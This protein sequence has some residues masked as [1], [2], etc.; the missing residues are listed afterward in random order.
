MEE[1]MPPQMPEPI[2]QQSNFNTVNPMPQQEISTGVGTLPPINPPA[3]KRMKW[4][5]WLI[6][7][8]AGAAL[9]GVGGLLLHKHFSNKPFYEPEM[10]LIPVMQDTLWGY[11]D[12]KGTLA[13][14]P[15]FKYAGYFSEGLA[16][17]TVEKDLIGFVNAKGTMA[18]PAKYKSVTDFSEGR[19]FVVE[20]GS[21]LVC[22]DKKGNTLFELRDV[23][24]A[25]PYSEGMAAVFKLHEI[26]DDEM[27]VYRCG[28][29]D[30]KGNYAI[31][32]QFSS[33]GAFCDG[34]AAASNS[35]GKWGYIDKSG[36]FVI[37]PVY[38]AVGGFM[39]GMSPIL[40][41]EK[42]GYIDKKG[43][44]VAYPQYDDAR[45][46]VDGRARVCRDG[47]WGYIDKKCEVVIPLQYENTLGFGRGS[48]LAPVSVDDK[49]GCIDREGKM[50]INP[51]YDFLSGFT[52]G[53]SLVRMDDKFGVIDTKGRLVVQPQFDNIQYPTVCTTSAASDYYDCTSFL[54]AFL[55]NFDKNHVDG[56]PLHANM[57]EVRT[58]YTLNNIESWSYYFAGVSGTV[59][60]TPE[61]TR[62]HA[63]VAF[64]DPTYGYVSDGWFS[65][66]RTPNDSA[67]VEYV[68]ICLYLSGRARAKDETILSQLMDKMEAIYGGSV[69]KY[70]GNY[71][72]ETETFCF[73]FFSNQVNVNLHAFFNKDDYMSFKRTLLQN[74][75]QKSEDV[76]EETVDMQVE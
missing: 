22:I 26:D 62:G 18:I 41:G 2:P 46:F 32:P 9:L 38:D 39:E 67:L 42:W 48:K 33:V 13:I 29:V 64:S 68:N 40:M 17:V 23:D 60:Y 61:I 36:R 70:E 7:G 11:V 25:L 43:A 66:Y 59:E 44:M 3:K 35:D 30:K 5:I 24:F 58:H 16:Q 72:L 31:Y 51:Q 19:A 15:Q 47:K 76:A 8:V 54:K 56:L 6:I 57:S 55:D 74:I 14:P 73:Y 49:W 34:L 37:Q 27:P 65:S 50:V 12:N 10:K 75:S 52:D 69:E 45:G 4:W 28:F 1:Q 21:C 53:L 71:F 63:F 20:P